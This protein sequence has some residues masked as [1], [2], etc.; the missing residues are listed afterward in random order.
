[1]YAVK[2]KKTSLNEKLKK[3]L[4]NNLT[5]PYINSNLLEICKL[6]E[7][8]RILA[9]GKR[10]L[11]VQSFDENEKLVNSRL[12]ELGFQAQVLNWTR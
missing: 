1:M 4:N 10:L 3:C 5:Q 12:N 7:N 2:F 6:S 9:N 11:I 8:K